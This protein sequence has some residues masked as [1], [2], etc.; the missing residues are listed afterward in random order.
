MAIFL[1][2]EEKILGLTLYTWDVNSTMGG[3][4]NFVRNFNGALFA[5][6]LTQVAASLILLTPL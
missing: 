3:V 4:K 1:L 2:L 6:S 5:P